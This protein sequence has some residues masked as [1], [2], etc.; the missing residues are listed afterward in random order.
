MSKENNVF[1]GLE[2]RFD[3]VTGKPAGYSFRNPAG[4]V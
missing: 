4:P 2:L 3:F 1:T